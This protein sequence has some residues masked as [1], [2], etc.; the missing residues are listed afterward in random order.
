MEDKENTSLKWQAFWAKSRAFEP[1]PN[2]QKKFFLTAAFPYPNSPQ[3][4]GHARTY[5]TTDIY[6]RFMRMQGYNVLFPMGFHVTGTPILAMAKRIA[7]KDEEILGIF[8]RIYGISRQQ[9]ANLTKP[10]DLVMYFSKE[11]EQG[12][13]EI[14]LSI[15]WRRKFY[16]SDDQFNQFIRWQFAKLHQA[17]FIK[18]GEHPVPWCPVGQ[19]AIGAHDTKGDLDP[20]IEET[21]GILFPFQEGH[22]ICSTYRPETLYGVTNIWVNQDATYVCATDG[23][24]KYYLAK[25]ALQSL[26]MQLSDLKVENE[27]TAKT[28]LGM[29]AKN[30]LTGEQVPVFAASFV[31]PKHG[32]GVVMCVPSDAPIDY[33]ALRDAGLLEKVAMRQVLQVKGF[34][35]FAA[36]ELVEKMGVKDQLDPKA[37]EAKHI[38]YK[39][40]A[41]EGVMVVGEFTGMRGV[42]A[43]EKMETKLKAE[44]KAL[45]IYEIANGPIYSRFGGL[46]GVKIVK[47]QWFIDYGDEKW[48]ASARECLLQMRILPEKTRKEYDYTLEWLKEK[49]CTRS[50][51][52]GTRFPFDETKM[53]EALSDSTVYMAFYTIAH[54]AMKMKPEQLTEQL[55]DYVFLGRSPAGKLPPEAEQMRTQFSYWYP[56]DSR[57]SASDLVHNHLTFL[58]FNHVAIFPKN[59]WPRQIATNGFVLM[60][61]KKMSKSMGNI[62][63]LRK[64]IETYGADVVRFSVVNGAE[65]KEDSDFSQSAA[66]GVS[67]RLRQLE[68]L[69]LNAAKKMQGNWGTIGQM[70]DETLAD[71][72][73]FSRLHSRLGAAMEQYRSLALREIGQELFFNT[74]N[75]LSWYMK[76][77]K[78]PKLGRFFSLWLPAL[79]PVMPHFTLEAWQLLGLD[80]GIGKSEENKGPKADLTT[81]QFPAVF[82]GKINTLALDMEGLVISTFG[83]IKHILGLLKS[84]YLKE[85]GKPGKITLF[86]GG[87][88][89]H[90]L[91]QIVIKNRA[92]EKSIK[93]AMADPEINKHSKQVPKLV[94]SYTKNINTLTGPSLSPGQ[95]FE[96]LC[97]AASFFKEEL[98]CDVFVLHEDKAAESQVQKAQNALPGKVAIL[99]E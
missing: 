86:V 23:K 18:K 21:S 83:D 37:I 8:E 6:A 59:I 67:S 29:K 46:V 16:S 92:A 98:G 65:L 55:F 40:S 95:E 84:G 20:Q 30:P 60:D 49:A 47:D 12:M 43:K 10:E 79:H 39:A 24:R 51:G 17:G 85:S 42:D 52:L 4:I 13:K 61:G 96:A 36:K 70:P 53:I 22:L 75:D 64:A 3:H 81:H 88:W 35:Q 62:M 90:K 72:W 34:G 33:L 66:T 68:E 19:T 58:I 57:H 15:D 77:T 69:V 14:G 99:V 56:L 7:Q 25:E 87:E 44:N 76:R 9:A 78:T 2:G 89:K 41:Y 45:P 48:K 91:L 28:L 50:A 73:F 1:E 32:T 82:E 54:I 11:I 74:L 5:T 94:L 80:S 31:D 26:S 93:E 63:P 97:D 71:R 27:I 38:L